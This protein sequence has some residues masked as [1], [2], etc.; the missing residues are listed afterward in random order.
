MKTKLK[1]ANLSVIA[2]AALLFAA[3][4]TTYPIVWK[5]TPTYN[6]QYDRA[7]NTVLNILLEKNINM[8]ILQ[9]DAGYMKSSLRYWNNKPFVLLVKFTSTSPVQVRVQVQGQAEGFVNM[10]DTGIPDLENYILSEIDR[11]LRKP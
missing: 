1:L 3:C 6:V 10:V 5:T 4:A 8:D 9:K 11:R 7:W 2:G